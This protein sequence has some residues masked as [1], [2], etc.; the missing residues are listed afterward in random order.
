MV[1]VH[2]FP[3]MMTESTKDNLIKDPWLSEMLGYNVYRVIL[4]E[5]FIHGCGREGLESVKEGHVLL[6]SKVATD[7]LEGICF[8]QNSGF[9][10]VDTNVVFK[11]E[12]AP[13]KSAVP[14]DRVRLARK[15][16][17]EEIARIAGSSFRFSRFHLDVNIPDETANRIKAEWTRNYF[18]GTRGDS[19]VVAEKGGEVTGFLQLIFGSA[20]ALVI[21]L[22]AVGKENHKLG[23]ARDM[24][25][26]AEEN[27]GDFREIRVGTQIANTP[28]IQFYENIGFRYV[29]SQYIFHY[30]N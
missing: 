13:G 29:S 27:S 18:R 26:Y 24:V 21:D 1:Q 8:L 22:I 14:F 10:L 15:E 17:E 11:K 9:Y 25:L 5:T 23:L 16:D 4:D 19:M 20:G 30:T 2:R 12:I 3:G 28:S 6:Y 7:D